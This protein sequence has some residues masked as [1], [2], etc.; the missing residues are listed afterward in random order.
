MPSAITR[1]NSGA[2]KSP[3]TIINNI[4][5]REGVTLNE[6]IWRQLEKTVEKNWK[7]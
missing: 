7:W 2:K 5:R 6:R 1:F 4:V 3:F